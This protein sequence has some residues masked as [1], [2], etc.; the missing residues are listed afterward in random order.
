MEASRKPPTKAQEL[1]AF[2]TLT[3]VAAPVLAVMIVSGYGFSVWMYQLMTGSL[4]T[5]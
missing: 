1:K 2:L 5:G 3:V 4:P